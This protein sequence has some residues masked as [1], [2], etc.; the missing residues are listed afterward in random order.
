MKSIGRFFQK[1]RCIL[2][3]FLLL[4][5]LPFSLQTVVADETEIFF[6]NDASHVNSNVLFLLDASGSM[7]SPLTATSDETRME[8]LKRAFRTVMTTAPDALNVGLMH[9]A[10]NVPNA[11][12]GWSS[13]KGVSFPISPINAPADSIIGAHMSTD[14]LPDPAAGVKVREYLPDI[15]DTWKPAGYTPIVDS[16]YEAARYFRGDSVFWGR[17]ASPSLSWAAHPSTYNG[18]LNCASPAMVDC[19]RTLNMCNSTVDLSTC[20]VGTVRY[21]CGT[22]EEPSASY[23]NGRCDTNWQA[24][25][26][27]PGQSPAESIEICKHEICNSFSGAIN[28]KSPIKFTC[29]KNYLVLMSD[30]K[31]EYPY[32][33]AADGTGRFAESVEPDKTYDTNL[34]S[35]IVPSLS[36]TDFPETMKQMIGVSS[37]V[38]NLGDY[39]SGVCGR[40]LT[41]FLKH[42]DQ[43]SDSILAENQTVETYTVAFG[44]SR[45]SKGTAYLQ[46]LATA[47]DG[48]F[49]ADNY[50]E[51]IDAFSQIFSNVD[52]QSLSFSSPSLS[53]D[54]SQILQNDKY[55]YVPVFNYS[56]TSAWSGNLRK[57]K[58]E[59]GIVKD[60][61][62][63]VLNPET[64]GFNVTAK[65]L[66]STDEH[67]SDVTMGGAAH[68]L[69]APD[70]RKLYTDDLPILRA[71]DQPLNPSLVNLDNTH[72]D[73][74]MIVPSGEAY[75]DPDEFREKLVNFVRGYKKGDPNKGVRNHMGDMINSK[76]VVVNYSD[77]KS[78]VFI[79]TNE[80]FLHA[81]DTDNG[82][83]Q[84]AYMPSSLLLNQAAF[85]KN[86]LS[87]KHI[88][89]I[90][91]A[92]TVWRKDNNNNGII[93]ASEGDEAMLFF[94]LRE[95][96]KAYYALDITNPSAPS[97]AWIIDSNNTDFNLG[98]AWSK[99]TLSQI[100][101]SVTYAGSITI[102]P[103]AVLVFGGGYDP[104][105]D[106]ED[107]TLRQPT[108]SL[109]TDVY[110]VDAKTGTKLWSASQGNSG[111]IKHGVAGDIR[112]LDMD[113]NGALDRLYFA[114][115]GG[116]VWR[117]DIQGD[118][119]TTATKKLS[120]MASLGGGSG[121]I[122]HRKFFYEPDVSMYIDK[123]GHPVMSI[124]LGSGYRTHP[125][126]NKEASNRFYVL[127][128]PYPYEVPPAD[129]NITEA[130]LADVTHNT[131]ALSEA[132]KKGWYIN[133]ALNS[134]KVLSS[135]LTFMNKVLFT[136][137]SLTDANGNASTVSA[138]E[139]A[140]TTSRAYV[141]D[142]KTG[143]A[144][145]DMDDQVS[146]INRSKVVS[147][148]ELLD[149]PQVMFG[150]M[151]SRA[152]GDCTVGDCK[153]DMFVLI[154]KS[155]LPLL[156]RDNTVRAEE[157]G[158]YE[159]RIDL[160]RLLPRMY[161]LDR[162]VAE[163]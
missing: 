96:G 100:A 85:L 141:L 56:Y 116:Y 138:C 84:W 76:P 115:T 132:D 45:A 20:Q 144:V 142:L 101:K 105:K 7:R 143:Q 136:S 27:Y 134:E 128:D 74:T 58:I 155:P 13:I 92:L 145:I 23:P 21:C 107:L 103:Q 3:R 63:G 113:G 12:Y 87:K 25:E 95:G 157:G 71:N 51:L 64:G 16:L 162:S 158:T 26:C 120:L 129:P 18:G 22:Y 49:T 6:Q 59:N 38:N 65:D 4:I 24:T 50:D 52:V 79:G 69:P 61:N 37:C 159:Q 149:A 124:A 111:R 35:N 137:F 47:Q 102:E 140:T 73:H 72:I 70:M 118:D 89:G 130:D 9:Y 104:N 32:R 88:W 1:H 77:N 160:N 98:R 54:S 90:D 86:A 62:G 40:E 99:P 148:N 81:I 55:V 66:W 151:T 121:S 127:R 139:S 15:V 11:N 133:M 2:L 123:R 117:V 93:E 33:G 46:S 17:A 94:G 150:Q 48:A 53:V 78:L 108:D 122:D 147:H 135:A 29:Q 119:F 131:T 43:I 57:F 82:V 163:D 152:G 125:L 42:T 10:N 31:P 114:D 28:Y 154:G 161:W 60:D 30:G 97:I 83:E 80:G 126:N 5:G 19:N 39:A 8:V 156:S 75:S 110:I 146:G 67:G 36:S 44:M 109:G 91:G 14:N 41:Q 68:K 106:I 34:L 153:Q 112:I